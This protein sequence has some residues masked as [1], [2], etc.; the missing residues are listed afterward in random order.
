M[1]QNQNANDIYPQPGVVQGSTTPPQPLNPVPTQVAYAGFF[2][3]F[4][5][6]LIDGIL[7]GVI[8][9]IIPGLHSTAENGTTSINFF[10]QALL[11]AYSVFMLVK[12]GQT[13]G[14]KAMGIK[15]VKEGT[16]EKL[17]V[18]S[19][20]LREVV[21]K[22]LSGIVFGMGYFSML[23]DK[24]KQTWHDHIAKSSVVQAK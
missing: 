23:W 14:K 10:G 12:Y 22:F 8:A 24:K 2:K 9:M 21:G 15:V 16:D 17:D 1:D 6:V 13:L 18:V 20:I 5:A 11:M 7:F 19:A 4:V 3:R